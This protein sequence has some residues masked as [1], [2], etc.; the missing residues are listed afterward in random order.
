MYNREP[1]KKQI[2]KLSKINL[3][4][5]FQNRKKE[6]LISKIGYKLAIL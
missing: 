4:L 2:F 5:L 1:M 3:N 6:F